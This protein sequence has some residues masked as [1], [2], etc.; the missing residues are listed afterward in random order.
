MSEIEVWEAK[1][2]EALPQCHPIPTPLPPLRLLGLG[3]PLVENSHSYL[4][5]QAYRCRASVPKLIE[6]HFVPKLD[7]KY[8]SAVKMGNHVL[9]K[10]ECVSLLGTGSF[11][12]KWNGILCDTSGQSDL[13]YSSMILFAEF[14][15]SQGLIRKTVAWCN[16]CSQEFLNSEGEVFCPLLWSLSNYEVCSIHNEPLQT[17]CP[18]C[19]SDLPHLTT[20][21]IPGICPFC[22]S[23]LI[24]NS[25]KSTNCASPSPYA[26]WASKN[27]G[28][29]L[30]NMQSPDFSPSKGLFISN[31]STL[32]KSNRF[33]GFLEFCEISGI[34]C[35]ALKRWSAPRTQVSIR[36]ILNF[37]MML[38]I[39]VTQLLT[40]EIDE[41][42]IPSRED[43]IEQANH[44]RA[45][46]KTG[47]SREKIV[48]RL[49]Q[50]VKAKK[51]K[52]LTSIAGDLD[53][54]RS[55]LYKVDKELCR[56][57]TVRYREKFS[58]LKK[59]AKVE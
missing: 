47:L 53:I 32:G 17:S 41:S 54:D 30:L 36:S 46:R 11:A 6:I 40:R 19:E 24:V 18:N 2:L 52:S 37:S 20:Y 3:T 49:N 55:S 33:S 44:R 51:P 56:R 21:R 35:K 38:S 7:Q 13:R 57:I 5:R 42:E 48:S 50:E 26:L 29:L 28:Q 14:L 4:I 1:D 9:M 43:L 34:C 58:P 59:T 25:P 39:D 45:I 16:Q 8:P 15:S 10:K 31:I 23:G 22:G 27:L 12:K